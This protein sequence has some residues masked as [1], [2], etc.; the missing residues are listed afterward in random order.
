MSPQEL[1]A[2]LPCDLSGPR[3]VMHP[4]MKLVI[5]GPSL[6]VV[7]QIYHLPGSS[8][9]QQASANLYQQA[10]ANMCRGEHVGA[11]FL[12]APD[13]LVKGQ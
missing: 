7:L 4:K 3:H 6:I 5:W 9:Y 12:K 10:S 2:C 13:L 11:G 8:L 1:L